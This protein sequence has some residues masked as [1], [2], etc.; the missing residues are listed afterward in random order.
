M[1]RAAIASTSLSRTALVAA[2]ASGSRVAFHTSPVAA[3]G[4]TDT[5]KDVADKVNKRVGK[6][7][8]SGIEKGEQATEATKQTVGGSSVKEVVDNIN[9]SAGRGLASAI[10]KGEEAT[11]KTQEMLGTAGAKTKQ[12]T[13]EAQQ[14]ANQ[15]AA[16]VRQGTRDFKSDVEKEVRK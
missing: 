15:T 8:A 3:K 13:T 1:F 2:S 9:K 14:K 12:K 5:V 16:G 4:M 6:A 7:L 11:T 10:E